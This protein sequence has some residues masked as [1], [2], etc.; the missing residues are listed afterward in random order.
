MNE[1][2]KRPNYTEEFKKD[3]VNLVLEHGYN[4]HEAARRLG[5]PASNVSRWVRQHRQDQQGI[6]ESGVSARE[7]PFEKG[8]PEAWDGARHLKKSRGLLCERI[9]VKFD[10]IRQH[11]EAYPVTVLCRLLGVSRS[12]FY[13]YLYRW[14]NPKQ[15]DPDQVKLEIRVREVFI[16]SKYTY[17]SRRI[18]RQLLSEDY[19]VGRYRVRSLMRKLNLQARGMKRYKVT[20]N[21]NHTYPVAQTFLKGNLRPLLPIK[22]GLVIFPIYGRLKG[23]CILQFSWTY[24]PGR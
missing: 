10:F 18:L 13:D 12:G 23:G 19:S 16:K 2:R 24:T 9:E 7:L 15:D 22:Y 21:S 11:R 6:N 8:K 5:I 3:A 14:H 17:G 20:T 1:K 4:C